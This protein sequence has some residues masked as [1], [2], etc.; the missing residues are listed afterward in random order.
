MSI[1]ITKTEN[2][3]DVQ[4]PF[5]LKDAFKASFPSARWNALQKVW[6]C[7]PRS[8]NRL[9]LW[10][11]A[12]GE[13]AE[14]I[15]DAEEADFTLEE[16]AR[17]RAEMTELR[18]KIEQARAA[19][20]KASEVRKLLEQER[21]ALQTVRSEKI[22]AQAEKAAGEANLKLLL[23]G[24]V[25]MAAVEEA[26]SVMARTHNQVGATARGQFEA[27]QATIR[28]ERDALRAAGFNSAGLAWLASA[29]FN[30]PDRDH[31]RLM[32]EGA[33]L[34]IKKWEPEE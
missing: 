17:V 34:N 10:A 28:K 32:P 7:G 4:F 6:Q 27:A 20:G 22:A 30:R 1:I 3:Y 24:V 25:N 18:D 9:A 2:G 31:V 21:A 8:G 11:E 29:S 13:A 5:A 26:M 14:A 33:L 12:A 19:T 16:V 23:S 15:A